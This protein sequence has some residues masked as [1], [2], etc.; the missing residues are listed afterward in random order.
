MSFLKNLVWA[1]AICAISVAASAANAAVVSWA[2]LTSDDG[3]SVFGSIGTIGVTYSGGFQ[4]DQLNNAGTDYWTTSGVGSPNYTQGLVNRPTGS[5]I[6]ALSAAGT[7]TITFSAPVENVFIA[8]N[9]WNG[10]NVS[11]SSPFTIVSQG[12][13]YWGCGTFTPNGTNTGFTGTGE[14]VGVLEF[15]GL[16]TSITFTDNVD[17]NW[18]GLTVG[19]SAVPEPSTWAMLLLGFAGLGWA[20]YRRASAKGT[21]AFAA[22]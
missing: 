15:S 8:F 6:I 2:S 20:A 11:F 5:D 19:I 13:G 22:V 12:C 17:E 7:G 21:V 9:S 10:A 16:Q 3:S 1:A 18:H 4:F 14:T